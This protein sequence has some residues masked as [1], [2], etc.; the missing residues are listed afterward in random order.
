MPCAAVMARLPGLLSPQC[1]GTHMAAVRPT[2]RTLAECA[3]PVQ[4]LGTLPASVPLSHRGQWRAWV[5]KGLA[6]PQSS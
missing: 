2:P 3:F 5:R 1:L 6:R 4:C